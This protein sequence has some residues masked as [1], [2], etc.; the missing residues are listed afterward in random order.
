MCET[1]EDID[2]KDFSDTSNG[3]V[4]P[5]LLSPVGSMV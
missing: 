3:L 2:T 1:K 5:V 4:S